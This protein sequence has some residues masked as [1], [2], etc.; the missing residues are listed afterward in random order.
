MEHFAWLAWPGVV[1]IV[2]I[3]FLFLFRRDIS[4]LLGRI[5]KI[6]RNGIQVSSSQIQK[7]TDQ[8]SSAEEL[9]RAFDSIT[10]REQEKSIKKDLEN[11]GLSSQQ[12]TIDILV[13][14]LAATQMAL[15][16]EFI[17]KIIWGSQ[18][19]I[20]VNLNSKPLGETFEMLRPFYQEASKIYPEAFTNYTFDQ[21]LNYLVSANLVILK[22][23]K[24]FIT[25]LGRDFLGYLVATGQTGIRPF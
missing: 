11:K 19:A 25:T 13:R 7:A 1:L 14:H 20:L 15:R 4:A 23:G 17:N 10:L 5:Q 3:I 6:S 12:E 8:K 16:F 9:M 24:Y 18:V 22:D 2:I 21:Y